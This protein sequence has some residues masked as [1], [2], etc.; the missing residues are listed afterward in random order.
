MNVKAFHNILVMH[1]SGS[2]MMIEK[3][4]SLYLVRGGFVAFLTMVIIF[5]LAVAPLKIALPIVL[6]VGLFLY[7]IVRFNA[8]LTTYICK[9]C[10]TRFK[11][12]LWID[13]CSPHM[14]NRKLLRC[15]H[16]GDVDWQPVE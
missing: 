13:F 11:V 7:V 10:S 2:A 9:N 16:C 8:R 15:P 5:L 6:G 12:S 14:P 1:N 3:A 4:W